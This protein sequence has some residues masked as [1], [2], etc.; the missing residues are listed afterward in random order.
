MS[1]DWKLPI[2]HDY[3]RNLRCPKCNYTL[4]LKQAITGPFYGCPHCAYT[5]PS[6]KHARDEYFAKRKNGDQEVG[7]GA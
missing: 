4:V 2:N 6:N 7:N 1:Q 5:C 3:G